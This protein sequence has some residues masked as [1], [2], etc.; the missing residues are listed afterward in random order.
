MLLSIVSSLYQ[1]LGELVRQHISEYPD[2]DLDMV[3]ID[4]KDHFLKGCKK[5][6]DGWRKDGEI[7]MFL[8]TFICIHAHLQVFVSTVFFK[9]I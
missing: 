1:E 9:K 8:N 2:S 3:I 5:F 7:G 4:F 6:F